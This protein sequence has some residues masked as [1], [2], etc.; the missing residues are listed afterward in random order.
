MS[1]ST[2]VFVAFITVFILVYLFIQQQNHT[3]E[4]DLES[5]NVTEDHPENQ[6]QYTLVNIDGAIKNPGV[7][8]FKADTRMY[9]LIEQAGGFHPDADVVRINL[10]RPLLDGEQ[11]IIPK[12]D[13]QI[14]ETGDEDDRIN[15]NEASQEDLMTLPSIGPATAK[16]IIE[17]RNKT[18]FEQTE[19]IMKVTGIGEATYREIESLI[20]V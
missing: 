19:D 17:Y 12:I 13:E 9:Q 3:A 18:P 14:T 1:K 8:K 10:A 2:I 5:S 15:L 20:R 16:A 11:I 4:Y 6:T 7:Y